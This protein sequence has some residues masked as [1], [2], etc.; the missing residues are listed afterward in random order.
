[1]NNI[2]KLDTDPS[3]QLFKSNQPYDGEVV[4]I[5]FGG[6]TAELIKSIGVEHHISY[7]S[8]N[9]SAEN[10]QKLQSEFPEL[11]INFLQRLNQVFTDVFKLKIET[12]QKKKFQWAHC[13]FTNQDFSDFTNEVQEVIVTFQPHKENYQGAK[14]QDVVNDFVKLISSKDSKDVGLAIDD[15][16]KSSKDS[17]YEGFHSNSVSVITA[18]YHY[19]DFIIDGIDA[20]IGS[21]NFWETARDTKEEEESYQQKMN[22][23]FGFAKFFIVVESIFLVHKYVNDEQEDIKEFAH[24]LKIKMEIQERF[25]NLKDTFDKMNIFYEQKTYNI[26]QLEAKREGLRDVVMGLSVFFVGTIGSILALETDNGAFLIK[27]G[28]DPE[29]GNEMVNQ[30]FLAPLFLVS[31]V[32]ISL[33]ILAVWS[34]YRSKSKSYSQKLRPELQKE[35]SEVKARSKSGTK[36]N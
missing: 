26:S 10:V 2:Y 14:L 6:L 32:V 20:K 12:H 22:L 33:F 16:K 18:F 24:N 13:Y 35:P 11:H 15:V 17:N 21:S 28:N 27:Y 3:T 25:N 1:M 4:S 19:A 29:V 7:F 31:L 30:I 36:S 23:I 9:N 34:V 8:K 5:R